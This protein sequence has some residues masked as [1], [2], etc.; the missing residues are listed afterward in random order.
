[1]RLKIQAQKLCLEC[2]MVECSCV[3][4]EKK[5]VDTVAK[6]TSTDVQNAVRNLGNAL[7]TRKALLA[8]FKPD[9]KGSSVYQRNSAEADTLVDV[10]AGLLKG[11]PQD[12]PEGK[13]I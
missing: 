9:E 6:R 7:A 1:M 11:F 8:Q 5:E 2:S 4:R 3:L 12:F 10:I 13:E